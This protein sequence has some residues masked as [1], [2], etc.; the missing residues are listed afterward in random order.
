[1]NA[2]GA[3]LKVLAGKVPGA[4]GSLHGSGFRMVFVCA[5]LALS[6]N[7]PSAGLA[8]ES[9]ANKNGLA[10]ATLNLGL[11]IPFD[12]YERY[13]LAQ[14]PTGT[15][16]TPPQLSSTEIPAKPRKPLRFEET[17]TGKSYLLPAG[18]IVGFNVLL[19][20]LNYYT[21]DKQVYGTTYSTVRENLSGRSVVD[22]DPFAVNQ[23][24]HPYQGSIYFGLARSSGAPL[25]NTQWIRSFAM[26]RKPARLNLST[27]IASHEL[28]QV[29]EVA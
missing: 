15:T 28:F 3:I 23:F 2:P 21:I 5:A 20:R 29:R 17:E 6:L 8:E 27:A 16:K 13:I 14:N 19:N 12:R 11:P 7:A 26:H 1:M 18:E 22:T 10:P 4:D 24:M 25:T 9:G